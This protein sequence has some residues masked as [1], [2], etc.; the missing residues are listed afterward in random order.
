MHEYFSS[1]RTFTTPIVYQRKFNKDNLW[2][3]FSEKRKDEIEIVEKK[4]EL[5]KNHI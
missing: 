3:E 4:V 1:Q 5:K 2:K